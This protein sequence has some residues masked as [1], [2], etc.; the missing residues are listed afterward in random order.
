MIPLP[1]IVTSCNLVDC[2]LNKILLFVPPIRMVHF[3]TPLL[4]LHLEVQFPCIVL[5]FQE[6]CNESVQVIVDTIIIV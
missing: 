6:Y 3:G 4:G 1:I 2:I 5:E